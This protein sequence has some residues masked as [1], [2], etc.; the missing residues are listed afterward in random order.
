MSV[1][2]GNELDA[3]RRS[4]R[5]RRRIS[6]AAR[7]AHAVAEDRRR[8][9]RRPAGRCR[10]TVARHARAVR[11]R[12]CRR[13]ARPGRRQVRAAGVDRVRA[14]VARARRCCRTGR[15]SCATCRCRRRSRSAVKDGRR[16]RTKTSSDPFVSPATRLRGVALEGHVAAVGGDRGDVARRRS[17]APRPSR[18]SRAR[19]C[20]SGGR[21]RRCRRDPFVSPATRFVASLSKAT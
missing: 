14:A 21:G 8:R 5:V 13:A 17:P 20:R 9:A 10:T 6:V 4:T 12:R 11:A 15:A 18:R 7:A 19:S 16:S 2:S 3:R 1:E